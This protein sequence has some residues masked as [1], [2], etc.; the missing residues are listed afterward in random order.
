MLVVIKNGLEG[1][2]RG[3]ENV[4]ALPEDQTRRLTTANSSYREI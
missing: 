2:L 1:G 4:I 3:E